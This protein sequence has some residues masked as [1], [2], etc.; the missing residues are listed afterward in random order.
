M[1]QQPTVLVDSFAR[2]DGRVQLAFRSAVITTCTSPNME[3]PFSGM[4]VFGC[5]SRSTLRQ[6]F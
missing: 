4:E 2:R 5:G 1:E 3:D 6:L